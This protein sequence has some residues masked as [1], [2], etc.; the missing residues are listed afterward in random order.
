[1]VV[2]MYKE[3]LKE[4]ENAIKF[5]HY[6]SSS[7]FIY[8]DWIQSK[9]FIWIYLFASYLSCVTR[10]L[11]LRHTHSLVVAQGLNGFGTRA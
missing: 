11:S 4:V 10:D 1:M 7:L 6:F 8:L 5:C 9:L 2:L 3:E